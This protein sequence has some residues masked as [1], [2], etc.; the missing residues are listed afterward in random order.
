MKLVFC[1]HL[2]TFVCSTAVLDHKPRHS[3]LGGQWMCNICNGPLSTHAHILPHWNWVHFHFWQSL[4]AT[5]AMLVSAR[6]TC[7][8]LVLFTQQTK[9]LPQQTSTCF[10][11]QITQQL[12]TE[13]YH[14][15]LL[16]SKTYQLPSL[17]PTS[18]RHKKTLSSSLLSSHHF[19]S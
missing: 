17:P 16:T 18:R 15:P 9:I 11:K 6:A 7:C 3:L 19:A 2:Q 13:L 8:Q 10:T 12:H 5:M 14:R 4:R 1:E